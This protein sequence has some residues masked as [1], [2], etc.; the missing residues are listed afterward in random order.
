MKCGEVIMTENKKKHA[1]RKHNGEE[2]NFRFHNDAKQMK[3]CFTSN[4]RND[5]NHNT[6][7][8]SKPDSSADEQVQVGEHGGS[9]HPESGILDEADATAKTVDLISPDDEES[10]GKVTGDVYTVEDR[11]EEA[12][13]FD[14]EHNI[15]LEDEVHEVSEDESE[16]VNIEENGPNQPKL[17]VYHPKTYQSE[18]RDFQKA[19]FDK[20]IWLDYDVKS[21]TASCFP[22]QKFMNDS[23]FE[24][25]N[26]KKSEKLK[27]H[28][29]SQVHLTAMLKWT[30]SREAKSKSNNILTQLKSHHAIE[31]AEN[32]DYLKILIE[33]VAFLGKQNI[34]F[35][36]SS[37][38]RSNLT[39]L[40][41]CN[42]GNFLEI[43]SLQSRQSPF[44]K[45][46]LE[47]ILKNKG[48]GQWTSSDIQNEL[49]GLLALFTTKKIVGEINNDNSGD[50]V[51]GVI[52]DE[53]SD[54]SRDEQISL[55]IS[56]ID[57]EGLKRESFLGFIKTDQTDGETIFRLITDKMKD[58]G[59]DLSGVVGLGFDGASNMSGANKG[60][61]TRFKEECSPKA[62]YI[63]CYGHLL[64]LA[65]KD[66]LSSIPLLR[67]TLGV[68]QSL[69]NFLE[70][71]PKRHAMFLK[72][73][74]FVKTLKSLSVTRWTAH[75]SARKGIEAE[76]S[77]IIKTLNQLTNECDA[78]VSSEARCLLIAVLDFD[79]IFGL[80][81]LKIILPHTSHLSSVVQSVD[82][83]I[84]KVKENAEL[85]IQTLESC[86][87]DEAF[88]AIWQLT[89]QRIDMIKELLDL[90]DINLDFKEAKL[91][92]QRPSRRRLNQQE[93][94][95]ENHEFTDLVTYNK[96]THYFPA[97]ERIIGE[98][99]RRFS[100]NDSAVVCSLG[101][102]ISTVKPA[103][104][105]FKTVAGHFELCE[106]SLKTDHIILSH[107]KKNYLP[108]SCCV[109]TMFEHLVANKTLMMMPELGKVV[110]ILSVI[111]ATSCSCERSFSCLRRLKTYLRSTMS[112]DR[113][114]RLAIL[115]IEPAFVNRVLTEDMQEMI[116]TFGEKSGRR[117]HFF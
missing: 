89:D 76:L 37:E 104:E 99:K 6:A 14:V 43:L 77:T 97:L 58:L 56:Y 81:L 73:G 50:I 30:D 83:D 26:W 79:F 8:T 82:I 106:D 24:F 46:R 91:P 116:D 102:L 110:K 101:K 44:L 39:E 35:R 31:V 7:S 68:M 52:A 55:V 84:V 40:S 71:S 36:G 25:T 3:L 86:R 94:R 87:N 9:V 41:D 29:E 93:L 45:Q 18:V 60:V 32:R 10:V 38:D 16:T 88:D 20:F 98:L 74:S 28:S 90:E 112:Q 78:K 13:A 21:A 48:H 23:H 12:D 92:R 47:K 64:N 17:S 111:P 103:D 69:Y 80:S 67:N 53:T 5:Y 59:L 1:S 57:S 107:V 42:R 105:D 96:I 4:S 108:P 109:H 70:A 54:I 22:C 62:V 114:S 117:S 49:I 11:N 15:T 33:T 95:S 72:Q 27:K 34:P 51:I 19:W 85:T 65:T 75:E 66:T 115:A 2:V 113:L 61:A 63:H 100:E